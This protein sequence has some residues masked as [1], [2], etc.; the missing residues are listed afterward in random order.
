MTLCQKSIYHPSKVNSTPLYQMLTWRTVFVHW[1]ISATVIGLGAIRSDYERALLGR[2]KKWLKIA[3]VRNNIA[4]A[5]HQVT[6][7]RRFRSYISPTSCHHTQALQKLQFRSVYKITIWPVHATSD[8]YITQNW[9]AWSFAIPG[10]LLK[11]RH[12]SPRLSWGFDTS[13]I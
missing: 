8:W 9:C 10:D 3:K 2:L 4:A 6:T 1:T 7:L 5:Q 11:P 13:W 12:W